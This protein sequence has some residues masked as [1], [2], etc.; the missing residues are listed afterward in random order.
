MSNLGK[1]LNWSEEL[2]K[3]DMLDSHVRWRMTVNITKSKI[4]LF[5]NK[6]NVMNKTR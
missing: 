4:M 6:T 5:M 3:F 1:S 2:T